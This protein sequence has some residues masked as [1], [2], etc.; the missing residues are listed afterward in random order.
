[1]FAV[2]QIGSSERRSPCITARMVRAR[3]GPA[4]ARCPGRRKARLRRACPARSGGGSC[5]SKSSLLVWPIYSR[6]GGRGDKP[7]RH[8]TIRPSGSSACGQMVRRALRERILARIERRGAF[9]VAIEDLGGDRRV[10]GVEMVGR[11]HADVAL[12]RQIDP[13]RGENLACRAPACDARS[14][15]PRRRRCGCR[16]RRRT[17]PWRCRTLCLPSLT[18]P[19]TVTSRVDRQAG[20]RRRL[21]AE[22]QRNGRADAGRM[23][24]LAP[25][26]GPRP[27][28]PPHR[29]CRARAGGG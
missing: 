12:G 29:S 9:A 1:M 14:A 26:P 19:S 28:R 20:G 10:G 21:A 13:D 6:K 15:R 5:A 11:L 22:A 7:A 3:E 2:V 17:S 8:T 24:E 18:R 4:R 27:G 16:R 23:T 25:R